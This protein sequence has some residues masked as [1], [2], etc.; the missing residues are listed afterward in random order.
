MKYLLFL[1]CVL[2]LFCGC[3][4]PVTVSPVVV[5]K[6]TETVNVTT[7][8]FEHLPKG[9]Y[10]VFVQTRRDD[11][12]KFHT[13][14]LVVDRDVEISSGPYYEVVDPEKEAK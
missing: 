11:P 6:R 14:T 7:T 1:A 9:K 5:R 10:K 4:I 2:C 12:T 13:G 3:S 8:G